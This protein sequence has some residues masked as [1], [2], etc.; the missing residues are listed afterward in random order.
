MFGIRTVIIGAELLSRDPQRRD[1]AVRLALPIHASDTI[2]AAVGGLLGE[3]SKRTLDHA[4]RD[5]GHQHGARPA[6]EADT[7][8]SR[9]LLVGV[10][11][12]GAVATV[13]GNRRSA[14]GYRNSLLWRIYDGICRAH[15]PR[16]RVGQGLDATRARRADRRAERAAPAQPPRH[17]RRARGR[18][19]PVPPFEAHLL[20]SRSPDGTYNDLSDPAMGRAGSRF[21]RNVPLER[22]FP[23]PDAGAAGAEPARRQPRAADARPVR[24]RDD[25]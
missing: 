14:P 24:A 17:E 2:S 23:M 18:R 15:R 3:T 6:R 25:A 1:R 20:T 21:G 8:L 19:A 9:R 22:T 12:L 4:D 10:A 11:F 5:L 13:V 7:E 16:P